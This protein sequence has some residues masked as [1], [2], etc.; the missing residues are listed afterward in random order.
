[1]PRIQRAILSCYDKTGLADLA[2]GLAEFDIELVATEGTH[3]FLAKEGIAA[4]PI[5][6][7]T[8]VRELLG[9]RVKTLH[10]SIHAGLL[11][12][13]DRKAHVEDLNTF[14]YKWIDLLVTNLHPIASLVADD[15]LSPDEVVEQ[16]DIG[17]VAM[18]RSAAKNFRYVS[19]VV[20]HERYS[21]LVHELRAHDGGIPFQMRFRLAQEA[22]QETAAYD[23]VLAEYLERCEPP[24]E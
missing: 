21:A 17:G 15:R 4:K 5:G 8:G 6:D 13:R 22:F 9:G 1:M 14:N 2:R 19:V 20:N 24:E 12:I 7:F 10:P 11:G 23:R 18:I 3:R 16:V